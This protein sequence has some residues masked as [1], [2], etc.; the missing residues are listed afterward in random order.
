MSPE[1]DRVPVPTNGRGP[2]QTPKAKRPAPL[3]AEPK[4]DADA[5][6]HAGEPTNADFS[7]AFSPKQVAIGFGILASLI[8]LVVGARRRRPGG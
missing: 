8:L 2:R 6:P 1:T 3:A 7:V 4:A 5:D